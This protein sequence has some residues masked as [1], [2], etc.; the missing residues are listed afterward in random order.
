MRTK[1]A[2]FAAL[3]LS[4]LLA[5]AYGDQGTTTLNAPPV[6]PVLP[7]RYTPAQVAFEQAP[8][9]LV[10]ACIQLRRPRFWILAETSRPEGTYML[11]SGPVWIA[12][13]GTGTLVLQADTYGAIILVTKSGP[14]NPLWLPNDAFGDYFPDNPSG[15]PSPSQASIMQDLGASLLARAVRALGGRDAFLKAFDA[16]GQAVSAQDKVMIPLL[17]QLRQ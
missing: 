1:P 4:P 11:I 5:F 7:I 6:D 17:E 13:N 12:Q 16:T 9:R 10:E 15:A 3:L 2:I 8:E 14:C